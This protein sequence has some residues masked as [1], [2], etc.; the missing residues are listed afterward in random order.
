M[1]ATSIHRVHTDTRTIEP[2][3]LFVALQGER[4]DANDMLHEAFAKGA[5]AVLCHAG[6]TASAYP[7]GLSRIEVSNSKLALA[8]LAT[9]LARPI[10]SAGDCR[11]RQQWQN[12]RHANDCQH[13]ACARSGW[14]GACNTW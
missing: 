5:A 6:L 14:C 1:D 3:D 10:R 8:T 2:G 4:F 7:A 12:H 13:L 11:D 9:G